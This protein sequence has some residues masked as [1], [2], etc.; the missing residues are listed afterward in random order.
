MQGERWKDARRILARVRN[1]RNNGT[2]KE[3]MKSKGNK[4]LA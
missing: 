4:L 3:I 1:G 2:Q